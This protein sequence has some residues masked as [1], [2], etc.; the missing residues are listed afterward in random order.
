MEALPETGTA[1]ASVNLSK[2]AQQNSKPSQEEDATT[3]M[4]MLGRNGNVE[5]TF[6]VFFHLAWIFIDDF[7]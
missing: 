2:V 6:I 1:V 4:A 7:I 5:W 3:K